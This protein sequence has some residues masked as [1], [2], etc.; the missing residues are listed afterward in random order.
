MD[1]VWKLL[2]RTCPHKDF[3]KIQLGIN[4]FEKSSTFYLKT[5]KVASTFLKR[6]KYNLSSTV[7]AMNV[8]DCKISIVFNSSFCGFLTSSGGHVQSF[9]FADG[10]KCCSTASC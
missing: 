2:E 9:R 10:S 3:L 7:Y 5:R 8:E 6:Y 4:K 1:R